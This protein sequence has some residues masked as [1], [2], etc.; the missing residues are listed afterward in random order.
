MRVERLK[1]KR[2]HRDMFRGSNHHSTPLLHTEGSQ[3]STIGS[4][5]QGT[6]SRNYNLQPWSTQLQLSH[7]YTRG[8]NNHL[9]TRW[10]TR[11][12][13]EIQ[14]SDPMITNTLGDLKGSQTIFSQNKDPKERFRIE[15]LK[16]VRNQSVWK[17]NNKKSLGKT[18]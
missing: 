1:I 5:T 3:L 17:R 13:K 9:Y 12:R 7:L 11:Q 2:K 8:S 10:S 15:W 14:L 18:S 16:Y 4:S 6:P